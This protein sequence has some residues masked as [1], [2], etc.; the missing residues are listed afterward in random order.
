[1]LYLD[2]I[3]FNR[4]AKKSMVV[5][6]TICLNWLAVFYDVKRDAI[7]AAELIYKY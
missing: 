1:M 7:V 2:D 4:D 3:S 6:Y 5:I